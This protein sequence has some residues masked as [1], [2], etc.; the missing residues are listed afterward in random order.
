MKLSIRIESS[1]SGDYV[2]LCPS[3]PGCITRGQTRQEAKE[4]LDEAIRGYIAAVSDFVPD[5]LHQELLEV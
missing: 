3:L 1:S 2:A 4:K 5:K